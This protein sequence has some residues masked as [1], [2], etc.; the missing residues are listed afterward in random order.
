LPR[1]DPKMQRGQKKGLAEV[2]SVHLKIH[3]AGST[4]NKVPGD[5]E[6]E[7]GHIS[8]PEG[9]LRNESVNTVLKKTT[10]VKKI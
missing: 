3:E 5:K 8:S 2:A 10:T 1:F 4:K 9:G 7:T 6:K